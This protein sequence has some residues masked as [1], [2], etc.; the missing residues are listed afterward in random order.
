MVAIARDPERWRGEG[1]G[2]YI[3][4]STG[5]QFFLADPRPEDFLDVEDLA[6]HLA[7]INRYTGGSRF[8]TAQHM[9]VGARLAERFYP[10]HALL[11]ARFMIHDVSEARYGDVSSPLKALLPDYQRLESAAELAIE[12][13]FD[14]T[15]LGYPEVRELDNRMWLTERLIIQ[16]MLVK[17]DDYNG[18][19]EPFPL[20]AEELEELFEGW[21][22]DKAEA[23]YLFEMRRLLPWVQW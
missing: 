2:P 10:Q 15:F 9:V 8:S 7:G 19:L 21:D 23:E 13:R 6:Y 1:R 16:P 14:L 5:K 12:K 11:P 4:T 18:P 22:P 20:D 3:R 17:E